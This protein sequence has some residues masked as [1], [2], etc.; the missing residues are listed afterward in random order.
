MLQEQMCEKCKAKSYICWVSCNWKSLNDQLNDIRL[1]WKTV[2]FIPQ[3]SSASKGDTATSVKVRICSSLFPL[4]VSDLL[5]LPYVIW[6]NPSNLKC[7][8]LGC[9]GSR[10]PNKAWY[11]L[12][13]SNMEWPFF[14]NPTILNWARIGCSKLSPLD[15]YDLTSWLEFNSRDLERLTRLKLIP[16]GFFL[17]DQFW[18]LL[19]WIKLIWFGPNLIC[20]TRV[21]LTKWSDLIW[22]DLVCPECSRRTQGSTER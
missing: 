22:T 7:P 12:I 8:E 3:N 6:S 21:V 13:G 5:T 19:S 15:Q 17:S 20:F 10:R 1:V 11:E 4:Y 16:P 2:S 14:W 18:L 9:F